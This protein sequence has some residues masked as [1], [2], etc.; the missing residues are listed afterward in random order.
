MD[1]SSAAGVFAQID[2]LALTDAPI[3]PGW[4]LSGQPRARSARHS[5]NTDGWASTH[6][7]ECSAGRFRWHFGVEET[8]LVL[9]GEVHVT[10][11]AGR[12][13]VL[14]AGSMGYFPVGTW[15]VWEVPQHVR[16]ISFNRRTVLPP[17][18]L[19]S[20]LLGAVPAWW[21]R[22]SPAPVVAAPVPPS[23]SLDV[24]HHPHA[25]RRTP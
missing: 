17:A 5:T 20:R 16:K 24:S 15:W 6:V 3:E 13:Q 7:W 19:L 10:D 1:V 22:R 21:R 23:T 9:E 2:T 14:R 12:T 8:V 11:A 4:V 25:N 18:R